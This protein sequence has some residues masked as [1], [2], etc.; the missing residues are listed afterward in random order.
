MSFRQREKLEMM[1]KSLSHGEEFQLRFKQHDS[2]SN[3]PRSL[4]QQQK[5]QEVDQIQLIQQPIPHTMMSF[6]TC[7]HKIDSILRTNNSW[8]VKR[9]QLLQIVKTLDDVTLFLHELK[10]KLSDDLYCNF[11]NF[12]LFLAYTTNVHI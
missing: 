1:T 7:T 5:N 4:E 10:S 6:E 12:G 2:Q 3:P 8:F 9:Y 11:I